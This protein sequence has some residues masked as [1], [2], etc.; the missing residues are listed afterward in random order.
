M[1]KYIALI[2]QCAKRRAHLA[3]ALTSIGG[4]QV[5]EYEKVSP[6]F[7]LPANIQLCLIGFTKSLDLSLL[8]PCPLV[9]Y[10]PP[11]T[12][13]DK[14]PTIYFDDCLVPAFVEKIR[15]HYAKKMEKED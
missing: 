5:T 14:W 8:K 3:L 10:Q 11:L 13:N 1:L 6:T 2:D 15:C 7:K 4:M 12:H 9:F